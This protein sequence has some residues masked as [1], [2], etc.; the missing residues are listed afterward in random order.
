MVGHPLPT[1]PL[2]AVRRLSGPRPEGSG[3]AIQDGTWPRPAPALSVGAPS[4]PRI[5]QSPSRRL[6]PTTLAVLSLAFH[7]AL[8]LGLA[9]VGLIEPRPPEDEPVAV[10][11]VLLPVPETVDRP[12]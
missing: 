7:A 8:F 12:A 6:G 2:T 4:G 11:L 3:L 5:L 10:D 9:A 1:Q